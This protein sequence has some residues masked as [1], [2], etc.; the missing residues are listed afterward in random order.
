MAFS[1]RQDSID[2]S[3]GQP[4]TSGL[5]R[6][7]D[8]LQFRGAQIE[9]E[10]EVAEFEARAQ[11][12]TGVAI[13]Q[14]GVMRIVSADYYIAALPVEVM[15]SLV[16]GSL[17]QYL[18]A[19]AGI[20][21]IT[22]AW[23]NGIQFYLKTDVPLNRGHTLYS[24][25][26]W[27]FTSTSQNQFWMVKPLAGFGDGSIGGILSV[28]IS[29]WN[30]KGINSKTAMQCTPDEIAAETWAQLKQHL[31]VGGELLQ[32]PN[33]VRYFLRSGHPVPKPHGRIVQRRTAHD[34]HGRF[35]AIP[36]GRIHGAAELLPGFRL[37][38]DLYGSGVHGGRQRGCAEGGKRNPSSRLAPRQTLAFGPWP[39]PLSFSR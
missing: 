25:S 33:L 31:N 5:R 6:G 37:C 17:K 21:N 18:P 27:A 20:Q 19:L 23:M 16:T 39:S 35:A 12:L 26:P 36:P 13:R 24:D 9:T 3:L 4:A 7:S 2:C 11:G 1:R 30:A 28:D 38:Q 14:N 8:Y 22:T 34:Q 32:D 10:V 15:Q 29:D